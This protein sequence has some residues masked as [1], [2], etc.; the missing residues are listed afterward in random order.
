MRIDNPFPAE[1]SENRG[2]SVRYL[3]ILSE[4]YSLGNQIREEYGLLYVF[5]Q[6]FGYYNNRLEKEA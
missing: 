1:L 3:E 2:I 4:A 5:G 6:D